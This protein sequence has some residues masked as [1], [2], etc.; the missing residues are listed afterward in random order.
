MSAA[1]SSCESG[2]NGNPA[3]AR[4]VREECALAPRL[5]DAAD[6]GPARP[7]PPAEDFERLD[8]LVEVVDLDPGVAPEHRRERAVRADE[9][10]SV[11]ERGAS[12]GL[13]ASDL[14]ADDGLARLGARTQCVDEGFL[15]PDWKAGGAQSV[16]WPVDKLGTGVGGKGNPGVAGAVLNSPNS[17][18]YVEISYAISNNIPFAQMINKAGKTVSANA[19]SLAS[20]MNDFASNFTDKLTNTIVDGPGDGTWP[21]AGYTYLILHTTSMTDCVKA[22]KILE[23]IRW[24]LTDPSAAKKAAALGYAVLPGDVQ[25]LVLSKLAAVTCNGNPVLK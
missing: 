25:K 23:Y 19:A 16:Q 6:T 13:G 22:Q 10:S 8:E 4:V 3:A 11:R 7:S 1:L 14:E 20:A 17:I 24:S 15:S 18:G 12:R 5:G 2:S 21:I 9:R